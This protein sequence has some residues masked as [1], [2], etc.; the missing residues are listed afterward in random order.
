MVGLVKYH[1]A[2]LVMRLYEQV[3]A[4][5][6]SPVQVDLLTQD[7]FQ[8]AKRTAEAEPDRVTLRNSMFKTC[9]WAYAFSYLADLT[10]QVALLIGP[11]AYQYHKRRQER[12]ERRLKAL[13][14]VTEIKEIDE[15]AD[16][17]PKFM[18]LVHKSTMLTI[19]RVSCWLATSAGA[20][21]GSVYYPGWG[22]V[23]GGNM[24]DGLVSGMFDELLA[25]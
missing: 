20:A 15:E 4:L 2:T 25:R 1:V 8:S 17:A 5:Y 6:L 22:T 12:R 9:L 14:G 24:A 3:A 23:M 21:F 19:A 18:V 10:V 13:D 7:T 11:A 16:F